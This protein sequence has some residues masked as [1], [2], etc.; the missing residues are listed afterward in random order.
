MPNLLDND[1]LKFSKVT[2]R[3]QKVRDFS[4]PLPLSPS[5]PQSDSG[6]KGVISNLML[7]GARHI[8][9]RN[10]HRETILPTSE[11]YAEGA[12]A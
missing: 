10:R 2:S 3:V 1:P 12:T 4:P 5:P 11:A 9:R 7:I 6:L 8:P